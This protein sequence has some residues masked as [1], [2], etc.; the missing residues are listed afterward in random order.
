MMMMDVYTVNGRVMS[1]Q[2]TVAMCLDRVACC[3][4]CESYFSEMHWHSTCIVTE[5]CYD[6]YCCLIGALVSYAHT[7]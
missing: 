6:F 2:H 3:V 5:L 1:L 4:F 7:S